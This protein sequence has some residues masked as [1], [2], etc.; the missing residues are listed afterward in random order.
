[1]ALEAAPS[2]TEKVCSGHGVQVKEPTESAKVPA[3]Q[4]RH[5][6]TD[7]AAD[8]TLNLPTWQGRQE[9]ALSASP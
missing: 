6:C 5:T 7:V 9:V 8:C 1:M 2:A 3:A 4:G